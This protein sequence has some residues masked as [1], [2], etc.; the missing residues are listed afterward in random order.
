MDVVSACLFVRVIIEHRLLPD[1]FAY[2]DLPLLA[3]EPAPR[4]VR[5]DL[6]FDPATQIA[7]PRWVRK[8]LN[9]V[10]HHDYFAPVFDRAGGLYSIVVHHEGPYLE[11]LLSDFVDLLRRVA[12]NTAPGTASF[13]L[14]VAD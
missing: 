8:F 11:I 9:T 12:N 5:D 6:P 10:I 1:G 13:R 7:F 14:F 2:T 3:Y 4:K